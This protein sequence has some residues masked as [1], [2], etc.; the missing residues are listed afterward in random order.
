MSTKKHFRLS[1]SVLPGLLVLAFAAA[2][3]FAQTQAGAPPTAQGPNLKPKPVPGTT[4]PLPMSP[5]QVDTNKMEAFD[6]AVKAM[7]PVPNDI[8]LTVE[9][10]GLDIRAGSREE[11]QLNEV[12]AAGGGKYYGVQDAAKLAQVFAK[13]A[14]GQPAAP[15]G[16]GG[17]LILP[18]SGISGMAVAAG[19]LGFLSLLLL[20]TTIILQKRRAAVPGG[21]KIRARLDIVHPDGRRTAFEIRTAVTPLGRAGD[22]AIVLDDDR[23]SSHHAHIL[24]GVGG[25]R[26]R[27]LGSTNGTLVRGEKITETTIYAGEEFVLGSTRLKLESQ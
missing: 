4:L 14:S 5:S 16:G 8:N 11:K 10:V 19:A 22:N 17:G 6:A 21:L 24:A 27:D 7:K 2:V 1:K 26:L 18:K 20:A 3:I 13:V 12:A 23:I 25:F 9:V 15:G